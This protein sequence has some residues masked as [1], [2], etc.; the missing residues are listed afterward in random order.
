MINGAAGFGVD[1]ELA[2]PVIGI[3]GEKQVAASNLSWVPPR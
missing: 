2:K 1:G 3:H